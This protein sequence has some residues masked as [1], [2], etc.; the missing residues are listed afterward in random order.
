M[1][2]LRSTPYLLMPTDSD[3][4]YM[5]LVGSNC[6]TVGRSYDNN[7]VLSDRW[8]SRNHAMLQCT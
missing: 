5:P 2:T 6:W 3:D 7:F 4:Q 1:V 8:I